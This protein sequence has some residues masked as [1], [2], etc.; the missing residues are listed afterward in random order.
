MGIYEVPGCKVYCLLDKT[1]SELLM[2]TATIDKEKRYAFSFLVP[3]KYAREKKTTLG[4]AR[5]M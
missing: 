5:S 2:S 3:P 1:G 4:Y